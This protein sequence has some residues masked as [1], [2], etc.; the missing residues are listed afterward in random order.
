MSEV[1][2]RSC[3]DVLSICQSMSLKSLLDPDSG[4]APC[5]RRL[6]SDQLVEYEEMGVMNDE[7]E[8]LR[9]EEN[10]WALLQ[11]VMPARKTAH[12]SRATARDL[13][14]QNPYTPTATLARAFTASSPLFIELLCV[15]EWLQDIAPLPLPVEA[16]TGYWKFTKHSVMQSLRT[17]NNKD[18][19]VREMDPDAANRGQGRVL[20]SEDASSDKILVQALYGHIRAGQLDEAVELCRKAYQPWRAASI[21]GSTLLTWRALA[22]EP[23]SKE[24]QGEGEENSSAWQGN[25]NRKLWKAS[26][27]RAALN[28]SLSEIERIFY[29]AL[30]PCPHTSSVL[31]AACR[32]WEDHLWAQISIMCEE[33]EVIELTKLE[34][35]FWEG[36]AEGVEKGVKEMSVIDEEREEQDWAN[37]V[38][39][40]LESLKGIVVMEGP[41][42]DHA[43]HFSQLYIILNRT[44][45]LLEAFALGLTD[46]SFK[47]GTVEYAPMCRFF[48]HLCL[49]LQMI[50]IAVPKIAMQVILESYLQVLEDAG[51]RDLIAM[52]A[53][54]LGDNAVERYAMFLVSLALSADVVERRLALARAKDHGLDMER[55]AV[56]TAERTVEKA[57][58]IL[59]QLKGPLPSL[60]VPQPAESEA[61]LFLLRSI[62]WT[63]FFNNTY[64]VALEQANVI[65]RYFLASGRIQLAKRLLETAP[66]DLAVISEP[67]D[68]ATEYL[69]YRQFFVIWETL[70]KISNYQTA[71]APG[72]TG[73]EK[74]TWFA[75]YQELVDQ[76]YDQITKLLMS[77]WL[78]TDDDDEDEKRCHELVRIRQIYI[79]ELV[80]RLHSLLVSSRA[81]IP[82]NLRRAFELVNIAADSRYRIYEDFINEGGIKMS[83]Y[84]GDVRRAV[85]MG[86]EGGGSDPLGVITV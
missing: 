31:K 72:L 51:Q 81:F 1:L 52:Y 45:Q 20:A 84:L 12:R 68:R 11:A 35:C 47:P 82:R 59:P 24:A 8:L 14:V 4:F 58:D 26:C 66:P 86:L 75:E 40:T 57:L 65:L 73:D 69:H 15:R 83:D 42:A 33:K 7:T 56:A 49:Y 41:P 54:A 36:G 13:L 63:T 18:G 34:G 38:T 5:L 76:A 21:R 55:V 85:F 70:E 23:R 79:P 53:S 61:E 80:M 16:T 25:R 22:T 9:L 32:T 48:A 44:S 64:P 77:D 74:A 3:A 71:F 46:G 2:L 10:T 78:V 29:A 39:E 50:D 37:E 19:L 62:E 17:G 27:V 28:P 67:E 30:V 43:F 6:C 60:I